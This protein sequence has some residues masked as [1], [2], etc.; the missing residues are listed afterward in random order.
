MTQLWQSGSRDS[1]C[2]QP[3]VCFDLVLGVLVNVQKYS[4]FI[5]V[6]L[7]W[8]RVEPRPTLITSAAATTRPSPDNGSTHPHTGKHP[9]AD[10]KC[11]WEPRAP[12][13]PESHTA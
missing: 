2:V 9:H 3:Y 8:P 6:L 10:R 7:T 5:L 1:L 12:A 4:A 13:D 11:P